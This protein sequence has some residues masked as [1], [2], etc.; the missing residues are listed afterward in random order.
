MRI[1]RWLGDGAEGDKERLALWVGGP[2]LG[3]RVLDH[4][5]DEVM[6]PLPRVSVERDTGC[7][8]R[9]EVSARAG[10]LSALCALVDATHRCPLWGRS[11]SFS[12]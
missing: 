4:G 10:G 3:E 1:G 7:E 6:P 9:R 2:A 5:D 11:S 12:R 8:S